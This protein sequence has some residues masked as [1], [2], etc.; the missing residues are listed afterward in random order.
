[1][2]QLS[3][4]KP[5]N[6]ASTYIYMLN[7]FTKFQDGELYQ[8]DNEV[9]NWK[10]GA[11]NIFRRRKNQTSDRPTEKNYGHR[12]HMRHMFDVSGTYACR[13]AVQAAG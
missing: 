4:A 11:L 2:L 5:G 1:M 13:C 8:K 6:P 12:V 7:H 10:L 9:S 3:R